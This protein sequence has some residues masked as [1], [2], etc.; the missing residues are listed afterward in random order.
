MISPDVNDIVQ[1]FMDRAANDA[2]TIAFLEAT[3]KAYQ[4]EAADFANAA[5]VAEKGMS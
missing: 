3:I 2:K 5:P 4:R 1:S